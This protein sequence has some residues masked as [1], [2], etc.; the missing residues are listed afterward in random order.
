[1]PVAMAEQARAELGMP[2]DP[3]APA[4]VRQWLRDMLDGSGLATDVLSDTLLVVDELV[5]NSVLHA[6]TP[7]VV[8]LEYSPNACR[9]SVSDKCATGPLPR[10]VERADGSGRGLRL[11]N[12]IATAWGVERSDAGTTVWAEIS[13]GS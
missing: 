13:A 6:A 12:A 3:T 5:T 9:C 11:V 10:I 1:M 2:P 8:A 7:I 4:Y